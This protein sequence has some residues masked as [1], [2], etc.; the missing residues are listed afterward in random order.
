[1][2]SNSNNN[3]WIGP[4]VAGVASIGSTAISNSG[5]KKS[6]ERANDYN[7]DFW[8]MQNAYNHPTQ[9]MARL[10]ESG[11]NPHLVYGQGSGQSSGNAQ[12]I[13]PAKASEY[14][15]DNPLKDISSFQ[16]F[17]QKKVQTDNLQEQ[18]TLIQQDALLR[19][20]QTQKTAAEGQSA[21]V[22]AEVDTELR[23]TSM[24]LMR[25][26]LRITQQNALGL[27]L[28]NRFKDQTLKSRVQD[29]AMRVRNAQALLKGTNLSNQ[30]K[31]YEKELNEI[32]IQKD[33]NLF[34]RILGKSY[35]MLNDYKKKHNIKDNNI[36]TQ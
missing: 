2:G 35:K 30:L 15:F 3:S 11:L 20:A 23:T 31:K 4:A 32:G 36:F 13:A 10:R 33:D 16:D 34:F 26:Q 29:V 7:V 6:Q 19:A 5:G 22:K 9:Q 12:S 14:K 1:M 18:N 17:K 24:D 25:E 21:K 8:N 28:D 27:E